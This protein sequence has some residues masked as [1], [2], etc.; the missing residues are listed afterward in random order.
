MCAST[1]TG[2]RSARAHFAGSPRGGDVQQIKG[3]VLK[4]RLAFVEEHGGAD[5]L[6]R[7][8]D[9]LPEEDRHALRA[10]LTVQW[11]PFDLGRRLDD[12]IVGVLGAGRQEFFLRLGEASA[13]RNLGTIHK[14]FLVPGNPHAFLAKAPQIY[15]LYYETGRRDYQRSGDTSGVLTTHD[16]DAFSVPDCLTVVGWHRRALELCGATEVRVVEEECRAKGGA[17][18][19]YRV[20]WAAPALAS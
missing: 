7:V 17:V 9:A 11:Y 15:A 16:A 5:G 6:H 1:A 14:T 10:L 13:D 3:A 18:C 8:L 20:S 4:S 2:S 19:R 12:A